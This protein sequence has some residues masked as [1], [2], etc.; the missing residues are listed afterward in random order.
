MDITFCW[1]K[2]VYLIAWHT[3]LMV[4][5]GEKCVSLALYI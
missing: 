3:L 1:D 5:H 2:I 4:L